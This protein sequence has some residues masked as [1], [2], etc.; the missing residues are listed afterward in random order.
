M[1]ELEDRFKVRSLAVFGSYVRGE[2]TDASDLDVLIEFNEAPGLL[3]FI[4][5]ENY[6]SDTLEI[7]VDLV[8]KVP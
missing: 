4:G 7:K 1:P 2:Q 8:L 3:E 6:L 5:L